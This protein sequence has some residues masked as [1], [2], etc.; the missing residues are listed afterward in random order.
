[1]SQDFSKMKKEMIV[2]LRR[3]KKEFLHKM[4]GKLWDE[5]K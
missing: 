2:E 3:N 1:M 4:L 5:L